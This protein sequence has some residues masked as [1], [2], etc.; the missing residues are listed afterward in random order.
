MVSAFDF[1]RLYKE[2]PLAE[3][4]VYSTSQ[5]LSAFGV[6]TLDKLMP[7][8]EG[9]KYITDYGVDVFFITLKKSEKHF[10]ET[11]LYEDYAIDSQL[12]HWQSQS[13][14]TLESPTGQRYIG[15]RTNGSKVMLFVREECS[16]EN[17]KTEVYTCLGLADYTS[18][19]GSAPISIIYKLREKMPVKLM[20]VSNQFVGM[21]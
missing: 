2:I 12:F 10:S 21:G 9:V 4:F 17:G 13:R 19:Q 1:L 11:T 18:H 15:Q 8:R 5:V 20:R 3:A 16:D 14:I 7:F 6:N